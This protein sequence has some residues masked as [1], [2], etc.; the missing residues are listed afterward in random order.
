MGGRLLFKEPQEPTGQSRSEI[1]EAVCA[2]GAPALR[3]VAPGAQPTEGAGG[4]LPRRRWAKVP[5]HS[6]REE[7]F[8]TYVYLAWLTT[9]RLGLALYGSRGQN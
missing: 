8:G 5:S 6:P 3:A 7:G 2:P 1:T 9:G 4:P